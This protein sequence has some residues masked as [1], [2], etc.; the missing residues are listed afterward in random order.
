LERTSR[1]FEERVEDEPLLI[2]GVIRA[3]HG[4]QLTSDQL[5]HIGLVLEDRF[6]VPPNLMHLDI[7]RM[8][9][10]IAAWILSEIA[11]DL[12]RALPDGNRFELGVAHEYPSWDRLQTLFDPL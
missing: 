6:E 10:E 5:N 3:P 8:R 4:E 7:F 11:A 2:L 9:V 1:E 12:R